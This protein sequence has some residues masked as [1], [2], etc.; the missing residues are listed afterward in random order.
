MMNVGVKRNLRPS[1]HAA[2]SAPDSAYS[3]LET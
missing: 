1:I 2:E 3:A